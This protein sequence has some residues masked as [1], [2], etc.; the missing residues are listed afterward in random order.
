MMAQSRCGPSA[1]TTAGKV[2]LLFFVL[3]AVCG[4]VGV[5]VAI[6]LV[7]FAVRYRRRPGDLTTPPAT[8]QSHALEWFW[9]LSPLVFFLAFYLMGAQVYFDAYRAPDNATPV[10][11]IGKQWMW[12]FQHPEGQREINVLHVP[13]GRPIKLIM[14]S[15]DVIHS[16][17]IPAFR[18]HMDLLPDRYTSV[19]FNATRSGQYHLFCSQYC[20]TS[21]ADMIGRVVVMEPADTTAGCGCG[22]RARWPCKAARH[23]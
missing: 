1:S 22:P 4:A 21:H 3:T 14:T 18:I 10:Y 7:Y 19:W 5:L 12:K 23:F 20:G 16:L 8:Y 6:L 2:D 17:F 13:R 15:E 11:V 9:T